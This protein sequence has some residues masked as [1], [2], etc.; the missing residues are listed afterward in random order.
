MLRI[1]LLQLEVGG[2]PLAIT[3]HHDRNLILARAARFAHSAPFAGCSWQLALTLKGLQKERLID[4]NNARLMCSMVLGRAGQ[5]AMAP[6]KSGVLANAT[7]LGCL[8]HTQTVDQC[9]GVVFPAL[10]IVQAS[11]TTA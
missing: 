8:A 6:E 10:G 3:H 11:K 9:L 1:K 7:S 2:M 4:L 5:E